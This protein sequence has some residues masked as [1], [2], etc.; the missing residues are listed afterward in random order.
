[1]I[2]L[3]RTPVANSCAHASMGG[4]ERMSPI[5]SQSAAV[6]HRL[7]TAVV[8]H[9]SPC[10]PTSCCRPTWVKPFTAPLQQFSDLVRIKYSGY[11]RNRQGE[12]LS[13][14]QNKLVQKG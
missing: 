7:R 12:K 6:S 3:D 14:L 1:M 8:H 11:D 13:A 10:P 2:F 4:V 9:P 5:H